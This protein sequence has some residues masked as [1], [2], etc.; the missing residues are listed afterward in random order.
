M[1]PPS[2]YDP[3]AIARS[4][5][6]GEP[7]P[8]QF[9]RPQA[10]QSPYYGL[11]TAMADADYYD[12]LEDYEDKRATNQ[13]SNR[14]ERS[15]LEGLGRLLPFQTAADIESAK[16][17]EIDAQGQQ[18]TSPFQTEEKI[19]QSQY[20]RQSAEADLRALPDVEK[21]EA[22]TR[23]MRTQ[24]A[25]AFDPYEDDLSK[26]TKKPAHRLAYRHF[27][28]TA[29]AD[30]TDPEERRQYAYHNA[31]QLAED[32]EVINDLD[33]AAALD[34]LTAAQKAFLRK[35]T[36]P[37]QGERGE[38]YGRRLRPDL[39]PEERDTI[40]E[41]ALRNRQRKVLMEQERMDYKERAAERTETMAGLRVMMKSLEDEMKDL[42]AGDPRRVELQGQI[43]AYRKD[44]DGIIRGAGSGP[45]KALG[46]DLETPSRKK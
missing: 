24:A 33:E 28:K 7:Y 43:T 3:L 21:E 6:T 31:L 32:D 39:T 27:Q 23:Q 15:R 16:A 19:A 4:A 10:R 12:Q 22:A 11:N 26:I 14:Y 29:P 5:F 36:V 18:R 13:A 40:Q 1:P 2:K 20:R 37:V 9:F 17:R 38:Y 45:K 8:R 46:D 35:A 44:L 41:V 42:P 34:G 25:Q 30:I